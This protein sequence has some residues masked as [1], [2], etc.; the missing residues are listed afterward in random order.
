V[1]GLRWPA[2]PPRFSRAPGWQ[3]AFQALRSAS[4]HNSSG[5][6]RTLPFDRRTTSDT[7]V[8]NFISFLGLWFEFDLFTDEL[9]KLFGRLHGFQPAVEADRRLDITVSK[10]L[11]YG[12]VVPRMVLEID[13]RRSVAELM[14]RDPKSGRYLRSK[15][16][17]LPS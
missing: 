7:V 15:R 12:L 4:G 11:P 5:S 9:S 16:Q 17:E 13:R 1:T 3:A 8:T 10:Q 2:A 14:N 6:E